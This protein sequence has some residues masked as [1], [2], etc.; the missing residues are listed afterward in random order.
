MNSLDICIHC[1]LPESEHHEFEP[2]LK[3]AGCV[4]DHR[5]WGNPSAIPPVCKEHRGDPSK[6]CKECEHD[7]ECHSQQA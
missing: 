7:K 2:V 1:G 6:N 5:E 3:P 4:C